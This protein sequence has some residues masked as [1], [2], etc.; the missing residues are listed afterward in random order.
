[1]RGYNPRLWHRTLLRTALSGAQVFSWIFVFQYFF[2]QS[3]NVSYAVSSLALTYALTHVVVVLLTPWTAGQLRHGFKRLVIYSVLA[4]SAAFTVLAASFAG[5]AGDFGWG[6]GIFAVLVGVYRALYWVPYEVA[7]E[8]TYARRGLLSEVVIGLM[9]AFAGLYLTT[10]PIATIALLGIAACMCVVSIVPLMRMDEVR[11]GYAWNYRQTFHEM[12]APAR[13]RVMLE[14]LAGGIE[15]ATLILLWPLVIFIL[16]AWSYPMLGIVLSVT[17]LL[18]LLLSKLLKRPLAVVSAPIRALLAASAWIMRLAVG[19]AVGV[20]LVDTYFYL[21]SRSQP[22]GVDMGTYE[23]AADG[24]TFV[25]EYTA[26]KEMGMAIGRIV[27]CLLVAVL[28]SL[29]SLPLTF[30]ITFLCAA[31]AAAFAVYMTEQGSSRMY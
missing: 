4:L 1:M 15:V 28:A 27:M 23:Q 17:Y 9:P 7:R 16:L 8:A 18:A 26:L 22:R 24:N 3:G 14:S 11:E 29:V 5:Y 25:D 20:V 21:G 12:F 6:V 13:R 2:V 31:A 10:G 19:G 30:L